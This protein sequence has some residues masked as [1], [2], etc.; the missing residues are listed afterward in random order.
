MGFR[1]NLG[2]NR[3]NKGKIEVKK[4]NKG[5]FSFLFRIGGLVLEKI[6]VY[7]IVLLIII[8]LIYYFNPTIF[9]LLF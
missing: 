3:Q 2:S 4:K 1:I 9:Y 8:G 7:V 5:L 6:L